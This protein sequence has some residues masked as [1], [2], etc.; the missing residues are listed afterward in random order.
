MDTSENSIF[1]GQLTAVNL[2][3][4]A[5]CISDVHVNGGASIQASKLQHQFRPHYS[6][7]G[8]TAEAD[9]EWTI[10]R[11]VG[12]TGTLNG[13]QAGAVT[14]AVGGASVAVDVKKNGVSVLTTPIV[15]NNGD[16]NRVGKA[17]TLLTTALAAGDELSVTFTG[18]AGGGTLPKGVFA[19][20]DLI[21]LYT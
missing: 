1:R 18:T 16:T 3:P 15:L 14:K 21:E 11:V 10:H 17:G 5:G 9:G 19:S 4:N 8:A 12:A 13:V 6:Q 20:L 7:E 2:V